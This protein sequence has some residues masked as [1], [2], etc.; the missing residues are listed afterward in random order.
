MITKIFLFLKV[1][2]SFDAQKNYK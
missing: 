1:S 2:T